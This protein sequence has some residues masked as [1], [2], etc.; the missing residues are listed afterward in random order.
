LLVVL[1]TVVGA[2]A[3]YE[4]GS[5]LQSTVGSGGAV[6]LSVVGGISGFVFAALLAFFVLTL[7][8]IERNT[9]APR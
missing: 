4:C 1:L 6:M 9:R 3:G 7:A 8:Q 2:V 5:F